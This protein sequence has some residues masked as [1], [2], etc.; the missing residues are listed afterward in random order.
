MMMMMRK[1]K[2]SCLFQQLALDKLRETTESVSVLFKVSYSC[3]FYDIAG[4]T[5]LL[6]HSALLLIALLL[7]SLKR[8]SESEISIRIFRIFCMCARV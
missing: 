3:E 8:K 4:I 7:L 6:Q 5:P 2:T 1:M